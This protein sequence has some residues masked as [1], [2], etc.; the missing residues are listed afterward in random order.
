MAR[1]VLLRRRA[2]WLGLTTIAIAIWA[3]YAGWGV[4]AVVLAPI[5]A[6]AI[7]CLRDRRE[8]AAFASGDKLSAQSG[9][10]IVFAGALVS[11]FVIGG[12]FFLLGA[13]AEAL[14]AA[15]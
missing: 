13:G 6:A 15:I 14:I 1:M 12:A 10:A 3:G 9:W 4:E 5:L 8:L 7:V 11:A 2:R